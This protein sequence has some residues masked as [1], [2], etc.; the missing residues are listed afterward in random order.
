MSKGTAAAQVREWLPLSEALELLGV[1]GRT[2]DGMTQRD[3]IRSTLEPRP[4]RKPERMYRA[5]DVERVA[6]ERREGEYKPQSGNS[7]NALS[8]VSAGLPAR[9][10][11]A[12][13]VPDKLSA[14]FD[15]LLQ[16]QAESAVSKKLWLSLDEAA[17]YSGLARAD[18][19][20]LCRQEEPPF[21]VRKSGGWKIRRASL[22]EYAG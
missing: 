12:L 15:R 9:T 21:D 4:G 1:S 5:G 2:L 10:E 20:E 14:F 22:E 8:A 17:A 19:L 3:E 7:R 18:L 6:R 11:V 13:A 16:F